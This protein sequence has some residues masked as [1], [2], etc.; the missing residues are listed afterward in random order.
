MIFCPSTVYSTVGGWWI[1]GTI[2]AGVSKLGWPRHIRQCCS[3]L[4]PCHCRPR[5][6]HFLPLCHLWVKQKQLTSNYHCCRHT[7]TSS[8]SYKSQVTPE[9]SVCPSLSLSIAPRLVT[10]LYTQS[11]DGGTGSWDWEQMNHEVA[12]VC[13]SSVSSATAK[14]QIERL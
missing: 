8:C 10:V 9:L 11:W 14:A 5:C 3:S 7:H 2:K 6:A 13:T 12:A 4:P 1:V